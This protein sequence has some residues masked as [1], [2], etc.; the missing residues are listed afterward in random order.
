MENTRTFSIIVAPDRE[1]CIYHTGETATLKLSAAFANGTEA[2]EGIL[3]LRLRHHRG[4]H[5]HHQCYQ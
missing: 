2:R 5:R 4:S 1:D 3:H